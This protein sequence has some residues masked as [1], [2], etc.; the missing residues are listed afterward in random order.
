MLGH[1]TLCATSLDQGEV[2][3]AARKRV[4]RYPLVS[5]RG[6]NTRASHAY[7][8]RRLVVRVRASSKITISY[9]ALDNGGDNGTY[10]NPFRL[11][12]H[13]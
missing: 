9:S 1:Y 11:Q 13:G 5:A 8:T 4:P 12:L 3:A 6:T 10:Q 7:P 2:A